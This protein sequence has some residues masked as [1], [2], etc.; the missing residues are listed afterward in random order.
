MR[1]TIDRHTAVP[2]LCP[3]HPPP[4]FWGYDF[5]SPKEKLEETPMPVIKQLDS[6]AKLKG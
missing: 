2:D 1:V 3:S 6:A 5:G 4:P